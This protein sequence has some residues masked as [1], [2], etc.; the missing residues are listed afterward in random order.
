VWIVYRLSLILHCCKLQHITGSEA[1][2]VELF[3]PAHIAHATKGF[4]HGKDAEGPLIECPREDC[5]CAGNP[6]ALAET[7]SF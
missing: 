5:C 4:L 3:S 2:A 6:L 7:R 1:F